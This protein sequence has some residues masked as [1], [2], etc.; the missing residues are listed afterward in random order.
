MLT[1]LLL[2]A[3]L[4][5]NVKAGI[6]PVAGKETGNTYAYFNGPVATP[7]KPVILN[8][9]GSGSGAGSLGRF[10]VA[11]VRSTAGGLGV[12]GVAG[13][14]EGLSVDYSAYPS[15]KYG[16][17]VADVRTGDTHS[18]QEA[19][20]GDTVVGQYSVQEP[21]GNVRTV[22]YVA[23]NNGFQAQVHNTAKNN[24]PGTYVVRGK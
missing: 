22:K 18:Q 1:A 20:D 19:R 24:N 8:S 17:R 2:T 15:Y 3:H 4:W 11:G 14:P 23:D 9:V 13:A 7:A 16:Y 12:A 5:Q 6:Y 21:D 10:G